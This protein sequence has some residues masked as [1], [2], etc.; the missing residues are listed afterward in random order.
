MDEHEILG[1]IR[2][3]VDEEH[4]LRGRLQSGQLSADEERSQL[5]QLEQAL[6]Q[7][8]DLLRQRRARKEAGQDPDAAHLRTVSEVEH[9][10]Q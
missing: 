9:Y 10:Q 5:E 8:W 7:C 1:R 3:L 2:G 6:D 4:E